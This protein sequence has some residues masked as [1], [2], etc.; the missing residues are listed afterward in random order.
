MAQLLSNNKIARA[1]H[2]MMAYRFKGFGGGIQFSDN[3]DDGEDGAGSK[4]ASLLELGG[5]NDVLVVVS[6]WYGGIHLGPDRVSAFVCVLRARRPSLTTPRQSSPAPR[7]PR[8]CVE[9]VP[10]LTHHPPSQFRHINNAARTVLE[11]GGFESEK[12]RGG[13][14]K[15]AGKRKG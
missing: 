9:R 15:R 10:P 3:S 8:V 4:M 5:W 6:R 11:G 14:G 12:K 7:A 1:T 2:N 13:G